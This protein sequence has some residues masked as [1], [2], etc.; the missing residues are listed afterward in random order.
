MSEREWEAG[1]GGVGDDPGH[2]V[3]IHARK[4]EA[5]GDGYFRKPS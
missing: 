3:V 5:S 1:H 4:P 2:A